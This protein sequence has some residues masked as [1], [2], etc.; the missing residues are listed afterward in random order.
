MKL[1]RKHCLS[2]IVVII[3]TTVLISLVLWGNGPSTEILTKDAGSGPLNFYFSNRVASSLINKT[4]TITLGAQKCLS[5]IRN[6]K[7]TANYTLNEVL[8]KVRIIFQNGHIDDVDIDVPSTQYPT[9]SKR[10]TNLGKEPLEVIVIPHSHNDPGWKKTYRKYFDDQTTHILTNM[11]D[12]LYEYPDMTFI[13][14][15]SCFLDLWWQNQTSETKEKFRTLVQS[16]RLEITSG[17]WVAPDEASPHYFALLD[18][19]IEGHYWVKENLGIV[20]ESS[21]N[22]DQFGYSST[23]PYL[24]K[25][26]GLK[27]VL[28]KRIHRGLKERFGRL[29]TLNFNWRQFWDPEGKEDIFGHVSKRLICLFFY[30]L[31]LLRKYAIRQYCS[32]KTCN[33]YRKVKCA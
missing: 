3:T 9:I 10:N 17:M 5:S 13:W 7:I 29:Q 27:N 20:P 18:Q 8:D 21:L 23:M 15:E 30:L 25:K 22:F 12:K 6:I 1:R 28:I 14:V 32:F 33:Y 31:F 26:A 19:M 11:V 16:G 2:K 24:A 4:K